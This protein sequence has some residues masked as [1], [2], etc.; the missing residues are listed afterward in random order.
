MHATSEAAK[1]ARVK[2]ARWFCSH[3]LGSPAPLRIVGMRLSSLHALRRR[4]CHRPCRTRASS[5]ESVWS[6]ACLR[7][8]G[9]K[10]IRKRISGQTKKAGE[11]KLLQNGGAPL[12]HEQC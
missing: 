5:V 2:T 11:Q 7:F 9:Q 4:S 6:G 1:F 12:H 3:E 8:A 10:Q